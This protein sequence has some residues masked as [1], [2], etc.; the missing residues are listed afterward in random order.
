MREFVPK[1]YRRVARYGGQDP[2]LSAHPR[3]CTPPPH[4]TDRLPKTSC[5]VPALCQGGDHPIYP[6]GVLVKRLNLKAVDRQLLERIGRLRCIL[7]SLLHPHVFVR[8]CGDG[9]YF[10]GGLVAYTPLR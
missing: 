3:C 5:Y 7:S 8:A 1:L 6:E 2:L 10:E 4:G 9:K